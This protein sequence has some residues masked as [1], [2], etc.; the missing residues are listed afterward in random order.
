[1]MVDLALRK[2][3][4]LPAE[5]QGYLLQIKRTC[6]EMMRLIENLLEISKIEEGKM[7]VAQDRVEMAELMSEVASEYASFAE[8][9]GRRVTV[10]VAADLPPMIADR[11]LLKR[12]LV[13]LVTNSLRHSGSSDVRV[14]VDREP[15]D[16]GISVRVIDRGRGIHEEDRKRIFEKFRSVR[17]QG[18]EGLVSDTGL[19]LPF[20]KLAVEL[21][22]GQ[23]DV[24]SVPEKETIFTV[25]LPFET[26]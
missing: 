10:E 25:T 3:A 21:M 12:V 23:I 13:N 18:R 1:M 7:P 14:T 20:C 16:R 4:D 8:E 22:G 9:E 6:R 17:H 2:S 26:L 5:H 24:Q 19:G 11:G 15:G